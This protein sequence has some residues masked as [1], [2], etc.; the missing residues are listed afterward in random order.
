MNRKTIGRART[1]TSAIIVLTLLVG[2]ASAQPA[3]APDAARDFDAAVIA[4]ERNH[5]NEAY[6]AFTGLADRGDAEAARIALQMWR[7]GHALYRMTFSA[8]AQQVERW[9]RLSACGADPSGS[10]CLQALRRP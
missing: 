8:N 10:A 2:A 3:R 9:Q 6:A 5:W 7:H 4:Y 1:L